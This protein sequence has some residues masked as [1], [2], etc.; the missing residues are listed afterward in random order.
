M[1]VVWDRGEATVAEVWEALSADRAL[2]RNTVQTMMA[3]LEDKGWLK[4]TA[5]GKTYRY[6][7][8]VPR[9]LTL[10][11][12][13]RDLVDSAFGGSVEGLVMAL[14]EGRGVSKEEAD[15]IRAMIDEAEGIGP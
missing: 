11:R 7:A 1:H 5:D 15:R 13:V 2:A 10:R 12:L 3:R 4:H 8:A 9:T 14:L 6:S